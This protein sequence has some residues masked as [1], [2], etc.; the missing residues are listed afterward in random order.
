PTSKTGAAIRKQAPT[1]VANLA[2]RMKGLP[3]QGSYDGYTSCPLVTG[4]GSLVLAEFD[5]DKNPQESFPFDQ[6]E[7][8]Y[9][10]YAMKAYGLPRMYWHGMLRGR[11]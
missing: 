6:G 4:Y 9:S 3:M 1:V 10:M 7:E 5:Y 2:A 11:A 8:R